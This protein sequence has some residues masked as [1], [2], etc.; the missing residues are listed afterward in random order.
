MVHM[1][2]LK[3]DIDMHAHTRT[4]RVK[5]C[6]RKREPKLMNEM[7]RSSSHTHRSWANG[8]TVSGTAELS[9]TTFIPNPCLIM[10]ARF[11]A[12]TGFSSH[13]ILVH[14]TAAVAKTG[15]IINAT[16][17]TQTGP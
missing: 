7:Q 4:H 15:F 11:L 1:G 2:A 16:T 6:V 13:T 17:G 9:K 14:F 8:T 12:P 10:V 5:Q 3:E